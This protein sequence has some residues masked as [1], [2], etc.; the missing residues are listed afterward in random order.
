MF[1]SFN[2]GKDT[3][4]ASWDNEAP[5][6]VPGRFHAHAL[7][8]GSRSPTATRAASALLSPALPRPQRRGVTRRATQNE[9][10][11][12]DGGRGERSW[13]L[14]PGRERV[15][16]WL[17]T[18][19]RRWAVLVG[20][21]CVVV[22]CWC[23]LPFPV[24]DPYVEE[25][26]WHLP[27][28]GE[29]ISSSES[30]TRVLSISSPHS[31]LSSSI[32]SPAQISTIYSPSL[33]LHERDSQLYLE[34]LPQSIVPLAVPTSS[35][36]WSPANATAPEEPP[37]S[38]P[39]DPALPVDANFYFF[40]FIYYGAYL[41]FALV[42]V[43]KLFDLYRLNWWPTTLGGSA[44]YFVF[45][46]LAL[47]VGFLLHT[48]DLDGLGSRRHHDS[49]GE[50]TWDWERKTTWVILAFG[51][52]AMPALAC[53]AKLRADRRQTYRRSLT[54]AQKTFLDR[55]LAQRMPRSYKRFLWFLLTLS[56]SLLAL[57][58]GQ[59][60]ATIYLS[61]LPH[62]NIDGLV[63]VWS[64]ILTV[65]CLNAVSNWILNQKVRSQA[66]VFIFRFY[67]FLTYFIFYRNLFA[68]LRSPD[69]A[70]TIQL[71]SS[72]W[73]VIWY[74]IS[75]SRPFHRFLQWAVNFDKEWDE[76]AENVCTMLYLRNL[77]ENVTM[78]AFL[79]WLTILHYGPNTQL[80]PFFAF[81]ADG[82][83]ASY[84]YRLTAIASLIIWGSE[85]ASSFLA[86]GVIWL[87]YRLDV[88][89]IGLDEFREHP[90]LVVACVWASIHVLS[91][92]LLF[93]IKLNF[94]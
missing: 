70:L 47:L 5:T 32:S 10:R 62:S 2:T 93:L 83:D 80:Y 78:V 34:F 27:W 37:E 16:S 12:E 15:E 92:L 30:T 79:G 23:S 72:S 4:A 87:V 50:G 26:P 18:W 20:V 38:D 11:D 55:Q 48:F 58:I 14:R 52:M 75:M 76:Y 94:R 40:L 51:T 90:E 13:L 81:D 68:R 53:F 91:D 3:D 33:E 84:S 24:T 46:S 60:F 28:P 57:V 82:D 49:D 42:F 67:Y 73:V 9:N 54:A 36:G 8:T 29:T 45:W 85:L 41:A 44:S 31:H 71:L 21:P 25:P 77:A 17:E 7:P 6:Y 89:N 1:T 19:W 66:L 88:T 39:T 65:Q 86:R 35:S 61:T 43:T 59:G 63:Y 22:W 64:W 69:Q 56:L 74:P